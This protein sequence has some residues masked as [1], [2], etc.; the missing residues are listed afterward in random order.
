[1]WMCVFSFDACM[2]AATTSRA[3]HSYVH[4]RI[5]SNLTVPSRFLWVA[6][7]NPATSDMYIY[8]HEYMYAFVCV[9]CVCVD[10]GEPCTMSHIPGQ[11]SAQLSLARP[12][13]ACIL[14]VNVT[15]RQ[16]IHARLWAYTITRETQN[17]ITPLSGRDSP[18]SGRDSA[19]KSIGR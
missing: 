9:F 12:I 3:Q 18:L 19:V 13:I 7:P 5:R 8:I 6:L 2:K 1:M 11:S 17:R 16:V 15:F 4:V 10:E 14:N